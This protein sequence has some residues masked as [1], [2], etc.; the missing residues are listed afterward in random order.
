MGCAQSNDREKGLD[1][2][3]KLKLIKIEL[4]NS[5]PVIKNLKNIAQVKKAKIKINDANSKK[6]PK[7]RIKTPQSHPKGSLSSHPT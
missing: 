1:H 3:A 7:N 6:A 5:I 4:R 2:Y